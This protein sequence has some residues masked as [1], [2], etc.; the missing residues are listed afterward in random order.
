MCLTL[1]YRYRTPFLSLEPQSV[2]KN[3]PIE[4]LHFEAE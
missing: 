4:P 3:R 1:H 2:S